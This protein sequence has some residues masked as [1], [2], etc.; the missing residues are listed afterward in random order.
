MVQWHKSTSLA[1][2]EGALAYLSNAA[3]KIRNVAGLVRSIHPC[4]PSPPDPSMLAPSARSMRAQCQ[5]GTRI[6]SGDAVRL[7]QGPASQRCIARAIWKR[8]PLESSPLD[9]PRCIRQRPTSVRRSNRGVAMALSMH[10][11]AARASAAPRPVCT[12]TRPVAPPPPACRAPRAPSPAC[13][14]GTRY[15]PCAPGLGVRA[16]LSPA[17]SP[18]PRTRMTCRRRAGRENRLASARRKQG[19]AVTSRAA[20]P[21]AARNA[22]GRPGARSARRRQSTYICRRRLRQPCVGIA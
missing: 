16:R 14:D 22:R 10:T 8:C 13:R 18:R 11:R 20:S 2:G 6:G 1:T 3:E 5:P 17:H 19:G 9:S 7:R 21:I 4:W 12:R 15:R